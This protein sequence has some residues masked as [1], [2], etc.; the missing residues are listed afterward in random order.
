MSEF[1]SVHGDP[2]EPRIATLLISRP[3]TN[4]MTRQVY[5]EIAAAAAEVS[6]RD[7]VAAVVLY[8]G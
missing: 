2:E 8:G 4:A 3:P 7:D 6:A 1:V 5:R